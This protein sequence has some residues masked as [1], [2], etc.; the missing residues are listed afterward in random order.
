MKRITDAFFSGARVFVPGMSG[1]SA[2]LLDELEADPERARDVHFIGV[3]F[4]GIGRADYLA[5]HS[6]VR[7]TAFFMSPSVRRGLLEDRAE[8]LPL[9]YPG[10]V[11][12]LQVM[13]PADVAIVQLSPPDE[14]GYCSPG[15]CSDFVPLVWPRSCTTATR[16]SSASARCRWR[17][18]VHSQT[19]G[20]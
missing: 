9:D 12:H 2:L 8:L 11:R 14:N 15:L 16:C 1:E 17:W 3:Q 18:P 6:S 10:I 13:A 20:G 4:P 7:Q 19:T 5:S